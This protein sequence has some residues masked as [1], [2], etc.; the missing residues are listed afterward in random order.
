MDTST[1]NRFGFDAST[2]SVPQDTGNGKK[3]K[4]VHKERDFLII[5][6]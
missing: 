1:S 4:K 3:K 6:S 2:V 5:E